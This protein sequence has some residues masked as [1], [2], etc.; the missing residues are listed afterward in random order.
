MPVKMITFFHA[1]TPPT[2]TAQTRRHNR[3]GA[4]YLPA[5]TRLAAATLLAIVERH[6]PQ[7]PMEGPVAVTLVWTYPWPGKGREGHAPKAT[8]PDLD[9]LAKLAL[10]AMTAAG[11]WHD[12]AQVADLHMAKFVGDMPGLAVVVEQVKVPRAQERTVVVVEEA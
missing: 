10:D 9:N 11:Y 1:F 12:D 5:G 2:A 6:A 8:R 4:T 3:S 7:E